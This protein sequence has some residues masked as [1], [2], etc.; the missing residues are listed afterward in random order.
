ME[1]S[2]L[3]LRIDLLLLAGVFEKF[4]K[5]SINEFDIDPLHC[6][7]LPGYTWQCG[8]IYRRKQTNASR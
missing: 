3:Y 7:S 5:V 6:F 4:I 8:L 2:N 1:K